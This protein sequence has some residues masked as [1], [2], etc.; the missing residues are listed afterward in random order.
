VPG[1]DGACEKVTQSARLGR[2]NLLAAPE[3]K[4]ITCH[5]NKEFPTDKSGQRI[6]SFHLFICWQP[7][8]VGQ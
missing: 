7:L 1:D 6:F 5:W 2:W 4:A 3:K 8:S